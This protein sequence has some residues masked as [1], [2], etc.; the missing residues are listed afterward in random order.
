MKTATVLSRKEAQ[1]VITQIVNRETIHPSKLVLEYL[2]T[3]VQSIKDVLLILDDLGFT[4]TPEVVPVIYP[5]VKARTDYIGIGIDLEREL[6]ALPEPHK[7]AKI[8]EYLN[9][10]KS[11]KDPGIIQFELYP[12]VT[13]GDVLL[14]RDQLHCVAPVL[15]IRNATGQLLASSVVA[16]YGKISEAEV[17]KLPGSK[18]REVVWDLTLRKVRL[19][20]PMLVNVSN[21]LLNQATDKNEYLHTLR[22]HKSGVVHP[23]EEVLTELGNCTIHGISARDILAQLVHNGYYVAPQSNLHSL[24]LG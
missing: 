9:D 16:K 22:Y 2:N 3:P 23:W 7:V 17:L 21:Q 5:E 18:L 20:S 24:K 15:A 1:S 14:S 12:G 4:V 13:V 10:R 19:H 6:L 8:R 11:F